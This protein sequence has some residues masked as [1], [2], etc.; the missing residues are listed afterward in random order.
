M[1]RR[2]K[3][4]TDQIGERHLG[5]FASTRMRNGSTKDIILKASSRR[6]RI[7]PKLLR[8]I[9]EFFSKRSLIGRACKCRILPWRYFSYSLVL[10][11]FV[12]IRVWKKSTDFE[13]SVSSSLSHF[14]PFS[15]PPSLPPIIPVYFHLCMQVRPFSMVADKSKKRASA[16]MQ[17]V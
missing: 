6:K 7:E 1:C 11:R 16:E 10:N 8:A 14:L 13:C 17:H 4:T 5:S 12:Q 15:L 3:R 9:R 2:S